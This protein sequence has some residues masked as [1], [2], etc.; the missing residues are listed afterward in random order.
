VKVS[1]SFFGKNAFLSIGKIKIFGMGDD[2]KS[3]HSGKFQ[4]KLGVCVAKQSGP[5]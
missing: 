3:G 1:V 2:Q 4:L 5:E